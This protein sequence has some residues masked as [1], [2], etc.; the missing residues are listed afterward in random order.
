[1]MA[2]ATA[3]APPP[4]RLSRAEI[5]AFKARG[6]VQL[7]VAELIG[8][9]Q[10][11]AWRAQL[12]EGFGV[13]DDEPASWAKRTALAGA[14]VTPRLFELPLVRALVDQLSGGAFAV[15]SPD[16]RPVCVFP[17]EER[18]LDPHLDGYSQRGWAGGFMLGAILYLNDVVREDAGN[19]TVCENRL[20]P[21]E[22][23]PRENDRFT[24]TGSG[25]A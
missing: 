8:E 15:I 7:D 6:F 17:G 14:A 2:T 10:L 25:Q 20:S 16:D 5:A 23:L 3:A 1:M 21:R 11:A 13:A 18:A 19:F 9:E 22:K 12:W 24:K 4:L